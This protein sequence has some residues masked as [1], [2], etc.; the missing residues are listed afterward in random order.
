MGVNVSVTSR[1]LFTPVKRPPV[2]IGQ[3]AWWASKLVWTQ[4]L[5]KES[6]ASVRDRTP[7]VHYVVSQ[8]P[9]YQ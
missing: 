7:V 2:L 4:R 8:Y 9:E 3:A 6:F 1:P 5:E